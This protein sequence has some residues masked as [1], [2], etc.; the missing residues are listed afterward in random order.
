MFQNKSRAKARNLAS[1]SGL[2]PTLTTPRPEVNGKRSHQIAQDRTRLHENKPERHSQPCA[3]INDKQFPR[4]RGDQ[5]IRQSGTTP[6]TR[7]ITRETP[8]YTYIAVPMMVK[9]KSADGDEVTYGRRGH[10]GHTKLPLRERVGRKAIIRSI[11][12]HRKKG[13]CEGRPL[14]RREDCPSTVALNRTRM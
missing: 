8:L 4:A 12:S 10:Q 6:R 2:Y 13:C 9:Y 3:R 11:I 7:W 14:C 5:S 1:A